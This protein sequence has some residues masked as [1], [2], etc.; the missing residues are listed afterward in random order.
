MSGVITLGDAAGFW[1]HG[2]I[3]VERPGPDLFR[4]IGF[5][6]AL[7]QACHIDIE[8]Q[9]FGIAAHRDD[10]IV[11]GNKRAEHHI[12]IELAFEP[13]FLLLEG[14]DD[15][16]FI[17]HFDIA[18]DGH[19]FLEVREALGRGTGGDEETIRRHIDTRAIALQRVGFFDI[20]ILKTSHV[21]HAR[22]AQ[23]MQTLLAQNA[24]RVLRCVFH[25]CRRNRFHN[26]CD[27][28]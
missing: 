1:H 6:F 14:F 28:G 11:R 9:V 4:T 5:C 16:D 27:R 22:L 8:R 2:L 26:R 13:G 23:Q 12:G 15:G 25:M 7:L 18:K 10:D 24:P 19:L 3:V 21:G 17:S 20:G